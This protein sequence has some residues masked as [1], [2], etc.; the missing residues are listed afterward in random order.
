M[1]PHSRLGSCFTFAAFSISWMP[2]LH[3]HVLAP[4]SPSGHCWLFLIVT[5]LIES[6]DGS[7]FSGPISSLRRVCESGLWG[8]GVVN[9]LPLWPV[10]G[11]NL[12]WIL[13][14]RASFLFPGGSGSFFAP[15]LEEGFLPCS[16]HKPVWPLPLLKQGFCQALGTG[17]LAVYPRGTL[18][19]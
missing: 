3:L 11:L 15:V 16:T 14:R 17:S 7:Q 12:P 10:S 4:S 2:E 9:I 8:Q 5:F 19:F 18:L 1:V 6:G 13:G